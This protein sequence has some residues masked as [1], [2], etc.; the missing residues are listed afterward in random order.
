[1]FCLSRTL[2]SLVA[3]QADSNWRFACFFVLVLLDLLSMNNACLLSFSAD[4][5]FAP[6]SGCLSR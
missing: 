5:W 6:F 2:F 1:M 3:K 4:K